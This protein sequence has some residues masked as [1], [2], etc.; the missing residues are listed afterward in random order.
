MRAKMRMHLRAFGAE[1]DKRI[2]PS[3]P[4]TRRLSVYGFFVAVDQLSMYKESQM[5]VCICGNQCQKLVRKNVISF[6][7]SSEKM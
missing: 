2:P 3:P 1:S 5:F 4:M 6:V 7:F